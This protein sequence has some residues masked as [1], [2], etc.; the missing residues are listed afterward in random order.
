MPNAATPFE[1]SDRQLF[2]DYAGAVTALLSAL[3]EPGA[4]PAADPEGRADLVI[5]PALERVRSLTSLRERSLLL[6]ARL[7]A[8]VREAMEVSRRGEAGEPARG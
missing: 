6:Q 4:D 3:D 5:G 7:L 2:R 1:E 8:R